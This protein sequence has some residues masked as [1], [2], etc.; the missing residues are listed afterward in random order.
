MSLKNQWKVLVIQSCPTLWDPTDCSPMDCSP[1]GSSVQGI[2]QARILEWVVMP[3]SRASSQL[4][5]WTQVSCIASRFFAIWATKEVLRRIR[6]DAKVGGW[7][8]RMMEFIFSE[9]GSSWDGNKDDDGTYFTGLFWGWNVKVLVVQSC[10]TL[11]DP[12]DCSPRASSVHGF[13]RQRYW[14]G[15]SFPSP[16]DL[17]DSGME[18]G[19]PALAGGFFTVWATR[20]LT[21]NKCSVNISS[22]SPQSKTT[23]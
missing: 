14:S 5:D 16:G 11:C 10:L 20:E 9:M 23:F 1:P 13:S 17:P 8:P 19:S 15:L 4:R 2:L 6:D 7:R 18:P 22:F 12:M 21:Y 3:S